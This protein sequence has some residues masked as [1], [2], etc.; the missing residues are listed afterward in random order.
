MPSTGNVTD[1][2]EDV[3]EQR[4]AFGNVER[5]IER[6]SDRLEE[7]LS[8]PN[9]RD[10]REKSGESAIFDDVLQVGRDDVAHAGRDGLDQ[11]ERLPLAAVAAVDEAERCD[12]EHDER[13]DREDRVEGERLREHRASVF[14]VL[15][16]GRAEDADEPSH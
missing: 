14:R 16:S 8:R 2:E 1:R 3:F 4:P 11:R 7:I 10:D 5:A 13:E 15:N 12:C 9:E 6:I